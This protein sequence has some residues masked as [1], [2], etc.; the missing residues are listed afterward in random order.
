VEDDDGALMDGG[1]AGDGAMT[2]ERVACALT[3]GSRAFFLTVERLQRRW[4]RAVLPPLGD[5]EKRSK[6]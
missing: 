1:E 6:G 2:R 4:A 5:G 3:R